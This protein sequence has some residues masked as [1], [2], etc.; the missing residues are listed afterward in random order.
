MISR[1][2]GGNT[3]YEPA[4]ASLVK[5]LSICIRGLHKMDKIVQDTHWGPL[6]ENNIHRKQRGLALLPMWFSIHGKI[7]ITM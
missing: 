3:A 5:S 1:N 2:G 7:V 6:E 4:I